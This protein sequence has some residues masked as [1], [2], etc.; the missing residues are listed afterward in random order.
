MILL[1][2]E[3][4]VPDRRKDKIYKSYARAHHGGMRDEDDHHLDADRQTKALAGLAFLLALAIFGFYLVVHL[5]KIGKIEDCL[6]AQ[7]SNC[8]ALLSPR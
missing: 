4:M 7:R 1:N 3:R 2:P 8:D 6:L 5:Q